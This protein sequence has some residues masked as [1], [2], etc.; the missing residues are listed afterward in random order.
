M[1][2]VSVTFWRKWLTIMKDYHRAPIALFYLCHV[3]SKISDDWSYESSPFGK[4]DLETHRYVIFKF[5]IKNNIF[6]FVSGR[7]FG[8]SDKFRYHSYDR[9][10]TKPI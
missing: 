4:S 10:F 9:P 8:N 3:L 1:F 5:G 2:F 7:C 6:N